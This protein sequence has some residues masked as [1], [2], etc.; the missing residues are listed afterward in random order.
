M[1]HFRFHIGTLVILVLVIGV[2]FTALRESNDFWDSFIFTLTLGI[3]LISFLLAIHRTETRRSFW[4]GFSL[5]GGAF[6]VVSLVPSIE[7]RM[8]T[9]KALAYIDSKVLR[10]SPAGLVYF[11]YD[12]DGKMDLYVANSQS[13][14]LYLNKG[15]GTFPDVTADAGL[16]PAGNQ[17]MGNGRLSLNI[18]AGQWLRGSV[19]SSENF[20]RIGHSL[21]AL[22]AAL[23]GGWL[24]R[25]LHSQ[26]LG[27]T[28]GLSTAANRS[29]PPEPHS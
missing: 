7:S 8:T 17:V 22:I 29:E 23:L 15:N 24:S 3:L 2:S 11:D 1:R 12:N 19:G 16:N 5:F 9:T 18:S 10:P 4:V 21:F 25:S 6:L 27:R 13:N 20:I 26:N 14:V 28:S